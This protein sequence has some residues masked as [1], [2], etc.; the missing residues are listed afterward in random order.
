MGSLYGMYKS[1]QTK[2]VEGSVINFGPSDFTGLDITI[3]VGRAGGAN[4]AY[5]KAL[6]NKMR[7]YRKQA[8]AETLPVE[9]MERVLREVYAETVIKDW[10]NVSDEVG[11]ILE[12]NVENVIQ[13]L[14]DLPDLFQI[15]Q[16]HATQMANFRGEASEE[17][18]KN[19]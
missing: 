13:V 10:A 2:E 19:S 18:A 7:P 8:A 4:K 3:T 9:V 15:I 1:D 11:N 14:A 12:F 16:E 5:Q 6:T 17:I